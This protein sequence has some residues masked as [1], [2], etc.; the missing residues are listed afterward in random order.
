MELP[1]RTTC[2]IVGAGPVGLATALALHHAG[3]K[4]IVIVDALHQGQNTSRAGTI[5]A[6][7]LEALD[8]IGCAQAWLELGTKITAATIYS[9]QLTEYLTLRFG[10]L[11]KY[12]R[13]PHIL[14]VPQ[15][16]T[17]RIFVSKL[18][19][20]GITVFRPLRV[21]AMKGSTTEDGISVMFESGQAITAKYVVGADGAKS[22]VRQVNGIG[23][24]EPDGL[25]REKAVPDHIG[26]FVSADVVFS[27]PPPFQGH[28]MSFFSTSDALLMLNPYPECMQT[29]YGLAAN[30][31]VHRIAF[32]YPRAKGD[33]PSPPTLAF[34][35]N[36]I[37]MEG[38]AELSSDPAVNKNPIH[39]EKIVA[40]STFVPHAAIADTFF[41]TVPGE[42]G[43][44]GGS[45][46]LAGDAAHLH[47]PVGGLG[48]NLGIRDAMQLAS[49]IVAHQN[50]DTEAL[51]SYA[52]K[53]R[54]VALQTIRRTKDM[55]G[56][57]TGLASNNFKFLNLTYWVCAAITRIPYL[58]RMFVWRL[59][60]LANP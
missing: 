44:Q 24:P 18:A 14:T 22:T 40:S 7:T 55:M 53:R 4:D 21:I 57:F 26:K 42:K 56:G 6:A 54:E 41:Y 37:N 34:V 47:S 50:G 9:R 35:Q 51:K 8:S 12:T 17:E 15:S 28:K 39:I 27:A 45:V 43:F 59:S 2:L 23:Y 30:E 32:N 58:N 16:M 33:P 36:Y 20:R 49:A 13:F 48:M 19:E 52:S 46:M 25:S 1:E 11:A 29:V 60:G 3:F 5:H 10:L 38:P 31:K